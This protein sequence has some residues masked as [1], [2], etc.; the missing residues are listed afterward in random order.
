MNWYLEQNGYSKLNN[1]AMKIVNENAS[2]YMN[3]FE[4]E[5]LKLT[6]FNLGNVNSI[7]TELAE[8]FPIISPQIDPN[9]KEF[10]LR[11]SRHVDIKL[12][13]PL[14]AIYRDIKLKQ[15]LDE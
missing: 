12:K 7:L 9:T 14:K 13:E 4:N 11:Y 1:K 5:L 3:A 10:Y 15:I 8:K 6:E 2:I